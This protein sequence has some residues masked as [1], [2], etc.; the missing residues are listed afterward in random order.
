MGCG[1][2]SLICKLSQKFIKKGFKVYTN[3]NI[4]GTYNYNPSDIENF[5]FEPNSIVFCDEMGLI[6]NNRMWKNKG[7][8]YIEFFKMCRQFKI[9]F[10]GFTQ[11]L[12]TDKMYL[13]ALEILS[14]G[15]YNSRFAQTQ[16]QFGT[17][18][19]M[20]FNKLSSRPQD[21]EM[22]SI[23]TKISEENVE[24][25][26]KNIYSLVDKLTKEPPTQEELNAIKLT[27]KKRKQETLETSYGINRAL[28]ENMLNESLQG[29]TEYD[30]IVDN[31]TAQDI[32]NVAKK[33]L[34]LNKAALTVVHPKSATS[35]SIQQNYLNTKQTQIAFTGKND[36]TPLDLN[37]ITSYRT[38]NNYEVIFNNA[39][40]DNIYYN[41]CLYKSNWTPKNPA[42]I[43]VLNNM[44]NHAGTTKSSIDELNKQA[45]NLG[46][47]YN[48]SACDYS[49]NISADFPSSTTKETLKFFDELLKNPNFTQDEF[50]KAVERLKTQYLMQEINPYS[51]L[52]KAIYKGTSADVNIDDLLK[53]LETLTLEDVKNAYKEIIENGTGCISATGAFDNDPKLK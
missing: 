41:Y 8:G 6:F 3:C 38:A 33:Y 23:E 35:N 13:N 28:G 17:D 21:K 31:M 30:E 51:K 11:A 36:K 34:D 45:D 32:L 53:G 49:I 15:L 43:D 4:P 50:E 5:T 37:K 1:K 52:N 16:R 14:S 25:L 29:L 48:M 18:L 47:D 19:Y 26:L 20:F 27:L 2:T 40:T 39:T 9:Q 44:L 10:H 46:I 22:I 24:P 7:I 42:A 12:D